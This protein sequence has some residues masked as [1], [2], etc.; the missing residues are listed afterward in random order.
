MTNPNILT[1]EEIREI[2][3]S[4]LPSIG[5][6]YIGEIQDYFRYRSHE[7]EHLRDKKF[8][9]SFIIRIYLH[10]HALHS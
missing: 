5:E 6:N 1:A 2:L 9:K 10:K 7:L 3:H 8:R 4:F